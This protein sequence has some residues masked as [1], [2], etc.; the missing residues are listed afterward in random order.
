M[1]CRVNGPEEARHAD[2]GIAGGR[3]EGVLFVHGAK[4]ATAPEDELVEALFGRIEA[5]LGRPAATPSPDSRHG[6]GHD[7]E[8]AS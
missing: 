5:E 2:F 7:Q 6:H 3:G 4:V 1:G 8:M